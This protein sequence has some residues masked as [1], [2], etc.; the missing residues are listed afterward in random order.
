M[1]G[2]ITSLTGHG[3]RDWLIQRVT[4]VV[5]FAYVVVLGIF[6]LKHPEISYDVWHD[7]FACT[8]IKVLNSVVWLSLLLHAWIGLWTIT[9]DY[10]KCFGIRLTIQIAII[11]V[12][13]GLFFWGMF[14]F[15]G[16]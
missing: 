8:T 15:W 6:W 10:L 2:N 13:F 4:A 9:T 14:V 7:F 11:L 16:V 5:V 3:L 1:V 12:L